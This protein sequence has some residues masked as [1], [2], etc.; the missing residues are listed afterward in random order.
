MAVG[1]IKDTPSLRRVFSI[2]YAQDLVIPR[3]KVPATEALKG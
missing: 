3:S 2:D 1:Q